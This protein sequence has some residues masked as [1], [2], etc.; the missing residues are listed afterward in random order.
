MDVLIIEDE[1]LNVQTLIGHLKKISGVHVMAV[2]DRIVETVDW[3]SINPRPDVIFMDI[4]LADGSA[5]EIFERITINSPI[6]FTTAFSEYALKAFKVNSI[7]YLLK[8]LDFESVNQALVKYRDLNTVHSTTS[9]LNK[10]IASFKQKPDYKSTLLVPS[11]S[12][13]L[14]PLAVDSIAFIYIDNGIAKIVVSDGKIVSLDKTLDEI[15]CDL[16]PNKFFR[17]NRQFIVSHSSIKDIDLWFHN[18]LNV[19]LKINTP[20]KIIISKARTPDF[21]QW[22]TSL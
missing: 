1:E 8:P 10:L 16:N 5:F 17:A 13:K 9:D 15:F 21:I 20:E 7:D 11:K 12:D 22:F 14:I 18:R 6:I 4:N 2:L 19:N 3:L